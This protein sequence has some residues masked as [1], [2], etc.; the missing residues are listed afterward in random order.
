MHT[1]PGTH[2]TTR[3]AAKR[4]HAKR[5]TAV[6]VTASVR[7]C[8][9]FQTVTQSR[10]STQNDINGSRPI[11]THRMARAY[12]HQNNDSDQRQRHISA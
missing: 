4:E 12:K 3:A 7:P 1:E 10:Q 8:H 2:R 6:P 11:G 9:A 5:P